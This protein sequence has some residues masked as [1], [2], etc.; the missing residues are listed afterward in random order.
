M[1]AY[2]TGTVAFL[3]TDAAIILTGGVGY[4]VYLVGALPELNSTVE[5]FIHQHIREDRNDLFGFPSRDYLKLFLKMIDISGVG[6]KMAQ[7]IM[8]AGGESQVT[9]RLI[10]GDIDFLTSISGVG[11]KTAQK[12][13]LEMKGVLVDP[14]SGANDE[15][16]DTMDALMSLGYTKQDCQEILPHLKGTTPEARIKEALKLLAR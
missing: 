11:K 12:I 3:E 5:L 14:E 16:S 15:D 6:T 4:R 7:K 13:V 1:I 2:I 8:N 9:Q 10:A